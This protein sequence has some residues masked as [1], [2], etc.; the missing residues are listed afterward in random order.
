MLEDHCYRLDAKGSF[1]Q[2]NITP[3]SIHKICFRKDQKLYEVAS[4]KFVAWQ[5]TIMAMATD[6]VNFR[7]WLTENSSLLVSC[8]FATIEDAMSFHREIYEDRMYNVPDRKGNCTYFSRLLR[9]GSTY[10]SYRI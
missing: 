4:Y 10:R 2:K 1:I 9:V 7:I 8:K 5:V 6:K 3:E